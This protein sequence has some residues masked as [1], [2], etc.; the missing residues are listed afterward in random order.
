[1]IINR[2]FLRP[3]KVKFNSIAGRWKKSKSQKTDRILTN[4][5]HIITNPQYHPTCLIPTHLES[6][7]ST[8]LH[9]TWTAWDSSLK[10]APT[11]GAKKSQEKAIYMGTLCQLPSW[12]TWRKL[13][14]WTSTNQLTSSRYQTPP[15]TTNS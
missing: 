12:R 8:L 11:W 1:M 9:S 14:W 3:T 7:T 5:E 13:L 10:L 6:R 4:K 15:S 2:S